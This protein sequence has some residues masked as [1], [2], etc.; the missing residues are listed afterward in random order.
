MEA[1]RTTPSVTVNILA[2]SAITALI[3]TVRKTISICKLEQALIHTTIIYIKSNLIIPPTTISKIT[4]I[5]GQVRTVA[6]HRGS[7]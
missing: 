4:A 1:R 3:A 6:G 5:Y 7:R 2:F